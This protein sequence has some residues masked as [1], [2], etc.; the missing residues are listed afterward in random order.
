MV[1][2][3]LPRPEYPR[4][5]LRRQQWTNLNGEWR[6]AFDD[7][8][9]GLA[10][11]WQNASTQDLG[12]NGPPFDR[13]ITVPFCY[14]ARLSGIGET[15]FHDLV[16]YARTFEHPVSSDGRLLLHFG[17]VDYR[18]TVWVNG[19]HVVSHEGG[20]T[21][22]SADVTDAL[23][24]GENVVVVRAEDPSRDVT[25]PRGKQY[26][27]VESEGIFYTR[28]TGIWQTVWLEPVNRSRVGSLR[29]TPDV[30]AACADLEVAVEGFEPGMSLRVAVEL[31]GEP[32]LED[33]IG[34]RS[35]L[36]DRR[37]PLLARGDAPET[38][39]LSEWPRP[40]LWS[41]EH[42]NLYDLRLALLGAGGET[43]DAVES[44]FG[45][46]KVE[47]RDGKVYLNGR[48]YYQRLVLDQG[49]FPDGILTAPADDDLRGDV[50]LAKEM[51]FT[52]A[53]KHQKV[54]DPRWLFW[55]DSLGLLVWGEMANAYQYGSE[56]VRRMTAEW[57][58]AV[59]R[60]YNH[61]SVVAWV[62][63][64]ESWG[65]PNLAGDPGQIE[66][67]LALYH[68]TRSLDGTRPVV[69]N[70]GWEH[71]L[72]DLCNIHDYRDAEALA[73]TYVSPETSVAATPANRPVYVQGHGYRGEPILITEFGGIAF[74]G[75]A[76][77]EGWGYST[78]AD[79]DEFLARYES[80]ID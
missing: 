73:R 63:M 79:A 60:D 6:F 47:T 27:R 31:D 74:S 52:G 25:I 14:Q 65:V 45:M 19:L 28:T 77:G 58:E 61:P 2:R 67:L 69:S 26:W 68:L 40:A 12:A 29:L 21:P 36:I 72:T 11:G 39:H 43:L 18:A 59:R 1:G 35:S 53:R 62:P 80:L 30:D 75:D 42:P 9:V 34:L 16:W 71:A 50:E 7:E 54:E 44:Y 51:G 13:R 70:D 66:H 49:Y 57:Q 15:A 33:T 76:S 55:A 38:P 20:H 10:G 3:D 46:R 8:S 22:F 4:P 23:L 41:P 48:P 37:L 78:V 56:Y 5:Q 32:V 64:N 17:A 24:D